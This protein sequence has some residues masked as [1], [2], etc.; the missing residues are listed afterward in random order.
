MTSRDEESV[1]RS[2]TL[3]ENGLDARQSSLERRLDDGY[4]RIDEAA[5]AGADVF[6]WESFWIRLLGEYEDVCREL[7]VAA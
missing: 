4:R 5:L 3:D 2:S 7:D 1:F 6:E